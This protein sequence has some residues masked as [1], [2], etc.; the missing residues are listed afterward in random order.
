MLTL[1]ASLQRGD[2]AAAAEAWNLQGV[3]SAW[4]RSVVSRFPG[5]RDLTQPLA[6]AALEMAHGAALAAAAAHQHHAASAPSSSVLLDASPHPPPPLRPLLLRL[7]AFPPPPLHDGADDDAMV[8][9]PAAAAAA[10]ACLARARGRTASSPSPHAAPRPAPSDALSLRPP[11]IPSDEWVRAGLLRVSL[12]AFSCPSAA[13]F[14]TPARPD[15]PGWRALTA[16]L[17]RISSDWAA[18]RAAAA[19]AAE[20]EASEYR[21]APGGDGAPLTEE[22]AEEAAYRARFAAGADPWADIEGATALSLG[23]EAE[24]AAAS[25]ASAAASR[26]AAAAPPSPVAV[27]EGALR[28]EALAAFAR[29]AERSVGP[30]PPL[31][32]PHCDGVPG[33]PSTATVAAAADAAPAAGDA[34]AAFAPLRRRARRRGVSGDAAHSAAA[35]PDAAC[36]FDPPGLDAWA[37]AL[38]GCGVG[39]CGGG[40]PAASAPSKRGPAPPRFDSAD[41]EVAAAAHESHSLGSALLAAAGGEAGDALDD[42]EARGGAAL[43]LAMEHAR[44]TRGDAAGTSGAWW[45]ERSGERPPTLFCF[46]ARARGSAFARCARARGRGKTVQD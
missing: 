16:L 14:A 13:S 19:A 10:V 27:F 23:F 41:V 3:C 18:A 5:Y 34:A 22:A 37:R 4:A 15:A 43:R 11:P 30:Q 32:H 29:S 33:V 17:D 8:T 35:F 38:G 20:A 39:S 45:G 46:A 25:A 12:R 28:D 21:R 26:A 42:D 44:L 7:L 6:L 40:L 24:A 2:E 1:I 9:S 31:P 36:R